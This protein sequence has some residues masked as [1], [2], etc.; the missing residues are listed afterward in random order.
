MTT[1]AVPAA[2][3]LAEL[4]A[5]LTG[6]LD[7]A[8]ADAVEAAMFAHP[9]DATLAVVDQF[10][11]HGARLAAHGTWEPGTTRA[12]VDAMIAG[13]A[14]VQ[15]I[16]AGA[17]GPDPK[18]FSIAADADFVVTVLAIG[19]PDLDRVDVEIHLPAH[20]T[21]KVIRDAC[22]DPTDGALYGL[23]ERPLAVLAFG[24]GRSRIRVL[25]RDPARTELARYDFVGTVM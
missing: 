1:P 2:P 6:E 9:D 16:D 4:D 23:C 10:L 13:G 11:R 8:A 22:V 19:R 25:A 24:A 14:R 20:G 15:V 17:P 12:H 18:R 5:Y 7:D 3:T 21:T